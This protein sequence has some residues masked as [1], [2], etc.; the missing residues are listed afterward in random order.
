MDDIKPLPKLWLLS[1][2]RNDAQLEAALERLPAGSGFVFRH[3]H[4]DEEARR[5]RFDAL[6]KNADAHGHRVIISGEA[7]Q[8]VN[9]GASGIYGAAQ[10]LDPVPG[11]LRLATAHNAQEIDAASDKGVDAVFLSPV[12]STRT[13][14]GAGTLGPDRF[15]E[16]AARAAMP[17]IALGGMNPAR[18]KELKWEYWGAIDGLS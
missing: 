13:H 11:L 10:R 12:F 15:H 9:W 18:A 2:E 8:A 14:P 6:K 16:L 7:K 1:D 5:V 4:L 3:Y 17:V